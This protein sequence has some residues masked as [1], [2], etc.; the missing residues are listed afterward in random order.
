MYDQLNPKFD[1]YLLQNGE[2]ASFCGKGYCKNDFKRF[3]VGS[4][5]PM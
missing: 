3:F 4:D 2:M 5:S 1:Q